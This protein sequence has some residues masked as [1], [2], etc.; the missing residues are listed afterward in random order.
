[1]PHN[2]CIHPSLPVSLID[3]KPLEVF[4]SNERKNGS[5]CGVEGKNFEEQFVC[6]HCD[7]F[8]KRANDAEA[9]YRTYLHKNQELK[10]AVRELRRKLVPWWRKL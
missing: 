2:M 7:K 3:G 5:G 6:P 4:C 8:Y 1:M 9:K 10:E